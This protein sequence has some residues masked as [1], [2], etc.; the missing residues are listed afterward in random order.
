VR[1]TR[2]S[3]RLSSAS[4]YY[5]LAAKADRAGNHRQAETW[6]NHADRLVDEDRRQ[7]KY[8]ARLREGKRS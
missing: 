8:L 5:R 4:A 2:R 7:R 6:R 3:Q 1:K